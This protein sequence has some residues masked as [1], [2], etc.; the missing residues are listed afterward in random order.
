MDPAD[1]SAMV[2][3]VQQNPSYKQNAARLKARLLEFGSAPES[4]R[5]IEESVLVNT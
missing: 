3:E 4:A 5:I 2:R 1:L